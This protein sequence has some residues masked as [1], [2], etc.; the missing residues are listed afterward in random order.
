MCVI[1]TCP[2]KWWFPRFRHFYRR[3][4]QQKLTQL[5]QESLKAAS[6]L[7]LWESISSSPKGNICRSDTLFCRNFPL[8]FFDVREHMSV[9]A[10][11][12][13]AQFVG[14]K[15]TLKQTSW[16]FRKFQLLT[17]LV[18]VVCAEFYSILSSLAEESQMICTQ[19]INACLLLSF[20]LLVAAVSL[21]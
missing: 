21:S 2:E 16:Q 6:L 11:P 5:E 19:S 13:S 7:Q 14:W 12:R 4:S 8:W 15:E 1:Y 17:I 18:R 9:N 10:F 20:L 3:A